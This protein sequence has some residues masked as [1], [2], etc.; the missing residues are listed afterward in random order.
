M[1]GERGPRDRVGRYRIVRTIG[2]G[3]M[4]ITYEA[5]PVTSGPSVALK[6]LRLSRLDDWKP[7]ELFKREADVLASIRHPA[8]PYYVDHFT[9]ETGEGPVFYI[10]QQFAPGRSLAELV[11]SGWRADE[12]EAKLSRRRYSTCWMRCTL[13]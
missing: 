1:R 7:V 3:G 4:G 8:V 2:R 10:V 5:Q 9:V 12:P 6:E 11:A 13:G